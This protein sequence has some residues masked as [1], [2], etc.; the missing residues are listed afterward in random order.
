MQQ[1]EQKTERSPHPLGGLFNS[2]L[3]DYQEDIRRIIGKFRYSNHHLE[4]EE[5]ASRANLSLLKKREDILYDFEGVFDK[6]AFSKVAYSYVRNIIGWSHV[7]EN[8]DKFLKNRLNSTHSTEEGVKTTFELAI[9]TEGVEEKGYESFDSNQKFTTLLHVLKEYCHILTDSELKI[10][11]CLEKGMTHEKI[12]EKFGFT[13]QA[14]SHCAIGLFEKIKAHFSSD[15]LN[16][17]NSQKVTE[18][19]EAINSFFCDNEGYHEFSNKDR[20]LL[21]KFLLSNIKVYRLKE[22]ADLFLKGKYKWQQIS[23]FC[24][25]NKLSFCILK[26]REKYQFSRDEEIKIA[27]L[28]NQGKTAKEIGLALKLDPKV[29]SGKKGHLSRMGLINGSLAKS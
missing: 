24:A 2:F 12:S 13:R 19:N 7:R 18:G 25:K 10:L 15:V 23:S 9:E 16:D 22:M 11:S 27:E 3:S 17:D 28:Y 14:V 21:R 29:I 26:T 1:A 20:D 6:N 5:I 8:K 4:P